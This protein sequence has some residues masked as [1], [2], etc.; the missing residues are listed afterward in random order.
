M[1]W[2][3]RR[4]ISV[5]RG[6]AQ[7]VAGTGVTLNSVLVGPTASEGAGAFVKDFAKRQGITAKEF[8]K[9]FFVSARPTSLLKRFEITQEIGDIVAFVASAQAN[10]TSGAAV[11]AEGGVL[12]S[13]L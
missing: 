11:C 7:T 12:T 5:A 1:G 10:V 13:I 9:Q 4:R 2:R 3:K 8:E 6:V